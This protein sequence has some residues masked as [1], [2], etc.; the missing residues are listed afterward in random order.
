MPF[1][2]AN[3]PAKR[4]LIISLEARTKQGKT[5]FSLTAPGPIGV[6]N[7]DLG[8]GG[9]IQKFQDKKEI[10]TSVYPRLTAA[11][12]EQG[13]AFV[14][15]KASELT[16]KFIDDYRHAL[17]TFRTV[18]WD[19]G[20]D[21]WEM[22]RLSTLGKLT[23]VKPYHYTMVNKMFGDLIREAEGSEANFIILAHMKAE[24]IDDK[25][26]GKYVRAGFAHLGQ[27]VHVIARSERRD[28]GFHLIVQE[29]R[30]NPKL[31]GVDLPE[32]MSTFPQLAQLVFPGTTEKDW[33]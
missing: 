10:H 27:A 4:Q 6:Q 22:F 32:S 3:S 1:E 26:T 2:R 14:I 24:Y 7:T 31:W 28:D 33:T 17:K 30:Q 11:D 9:V 18:T 29:C 5:H 16:A 21:I 8:L 19:T 13:E 15:N 20:G 23:Q 25:A 12:L